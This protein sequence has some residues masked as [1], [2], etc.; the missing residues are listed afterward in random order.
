MFSQTTTVIITVVFVAIVCFMAGQ[1]QGRWRSMRLLKRAKLALIDYR[2]LASN[3]LG[4]AGYHLNGDLLT[5]DDIDQY[6]FKDLFEAD[7]IISE[8]K[9]LEEDMDKKKSVKVEIEDIEGEQIR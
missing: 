3:S 5:W 8:I 4:V 7:Q 6:G 1:K 9:Y 2:N